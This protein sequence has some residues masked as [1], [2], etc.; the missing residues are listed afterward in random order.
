MAVC[1]QQLHK[2]MRKFG[3]P[4]KTD[5]NETEENYEKIQLGGTVS[6]SFE[7]T[8]GLTRW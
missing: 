5:N 7:N 2:I 6:D 3:V 4:T 8:S 1:H